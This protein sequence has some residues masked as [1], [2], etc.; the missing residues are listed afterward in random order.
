MYKSPKR[1]GFMPLPE[2]KP[3]DLE[4]LPIE[5]A[6]TIP[7]DWY[8]DPA[9]FEFDQKKLFAAHW[10]YFGHVSQLRQVGDFIVGDVAG[11]PVIVVRDKQENLRA[12]YNVCRHRAGPLATEN[13]NAKLLRCQY[14]GWSYNLEGE[15]IGTPK[16][17]GV[18]GFD[19][20]N[21]RLPQVNVATYAG[22][23][24]V[25]L[26]PDPEPLTSI[27]SGIQERILPMTLQTMRFH[28]R[29]TYQI[30]CNWKV[31]VDNYMEGYHIP[32]IHP[33][34]NSILDASG[35][36]TECGENVVLQYSPFNGSAK[37]ENIYSKRAGDAAFYYFVFPNIMLNILPGRLQVNSILPL[38]RD[39]TLTIFDYFYAD[40]ES[41][42]AKKHI[43]EDL[44]YSDI[45]QNQD[46]KI[47]ELVQRGLAS[48][49]YEQGRLSVLEER[50]VYH[51]QSSLKR[52]YREALGR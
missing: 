31:Y 43:S 5:R 4:V 29:V 27:L 48:T 7:S 3:T 25:N 35:Y 46:I 14:H 6:S 51:F 20:K 21:C 39:L 40:L 17:E 41:V 47:C 11:N 22:I 16:F 52:A 50:G 26:A 49:A 24:F 42:E 32:S 13:G 12:F 34:L 9:F 8:T 38:D 18:E 30:K 19:K 23:V 1:G 36:V 44:R 33:E 2:I 37:I 15:L 45:V 28:S 10:Q